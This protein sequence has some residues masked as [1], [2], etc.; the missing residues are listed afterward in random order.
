[1]LSHMIF[2]R[3]MKITLSNNHQAQLRFWKT[4]SSYSETCTASLKLRCHE[5]PSI[6]HIQCSEDQKECKMQIFECLNFEK[7]KFLLKKMMTFFYYFF[8]YL[9]HTC[10]EN[11][12]SSLFLPCAGKLRA[13]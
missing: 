1:M 9:Q 11:I 8:P 10:H 4:C 7:S 2:H 13:G 12:H 3:G 5:M 6:C